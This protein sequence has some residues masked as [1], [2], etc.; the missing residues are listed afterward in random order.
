LSE[1]GAPKLSGASTR[2]FGV[3]PIRL[4]LGAGAVAAA[5]ARGLGTGPALVAAT[6]GAVVL[7]VIALGKGSRAG[8]RDP[9][10]ALPVPP[11]ASFDRPWTAALLAC[12]P[13]TLGVSVMAAVA[14]AFSPALAAVLGGVLLSLGVLALV[15]ALELV[16]RE[17]REGKRYW[18]ERGQRPRRFVSAR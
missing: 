14:L 4:A 2:A 13:S 17:R 3:A 6:A 10:N 15:A 9:G 16:R 7:A 1:V 8:L 18:L 12:I 11:E 5:L